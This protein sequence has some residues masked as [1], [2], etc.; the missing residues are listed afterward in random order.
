MRK[1]LLTKEEWEGI[2]RARARHLDLLKAHY[3]S[4]EGAYAAYVRDE[5]CDKAA[6][7]VAGV[8]FPA[9]IQ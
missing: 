6:E 9:P 5:I 4:L 1:Y 8:Q 7:R 2:K 3:Q